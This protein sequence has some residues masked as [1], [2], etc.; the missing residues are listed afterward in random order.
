MANKTK[1][2]LDADVIIHFIKG[3][4]FSILFDVFPEYDFIVLDVVYK[5]LNRDNKR[6]IDGSCQILKK[7]EK[8]PF[9]PTGDSM[10]DYFRLIQTMGK[11]E[12]ACLVYC[13]DH[14]DVLG[15]S[16]LKDISNFCSQHKITYLTTLDFLYYAYVRGKLT[17]IE[18]NDFIL[19]VKIKGSKLPTEITDILTYVCTVAI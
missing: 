7:I 18:C 5:E 1:I 19:K 2:V 9:K 3:E 14:N 15:S 8:I 4:C 10:R 17:V 16:N 12:S 11:G 6:M 13:K